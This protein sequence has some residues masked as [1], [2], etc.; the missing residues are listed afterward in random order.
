MKK[1]YFPMV[2]AALALWGFGVWVDRSSLLMYMDVPSLVVV[3]C[4][5]FFLSLGV[6]GLR[7]MGRAFTAGWR[8][9]LSET[10]LR[11]ALAYFDALQQYLIISGVIGTLIG[12]TTILGQY[13][14]SGSVGKGM[15]LSLLTVLY[16]LVFMMV[17]VI[18]F[19]SGIR[20]RLAEAGK[21]D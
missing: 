2:A 20:K 16:S 15:A 9:G 4:P 10:E 8:D 3:V 19:R 6:F 18:P 12:V 5:A 21:A 1:T 13:G 14:D 7:E 17:I 11:K